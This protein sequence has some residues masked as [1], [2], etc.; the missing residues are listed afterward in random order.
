MI[1]D[2]KLGMLLISS[3]QGVRRMRT[4]ASFKWVSALCPKRLHEMQEGAAV[5]AP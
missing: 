3:S 2:S 4:S 1:I 5:M